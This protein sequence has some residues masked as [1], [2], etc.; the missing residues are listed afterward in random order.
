MPVRTD[1]RT[2]AA[3]M[4][5]DVTAV[6]LFAA[7]GR[8]SHDEGLT[9]AGVAETA[10]PFLAGLGVGWVVSRG[11]R[12]PASLAPTGVTVWVCTVGVGML[13]RR[14]TSSGT[15]VSFV[16]VAGL[17]TGG[18]LVGWR[19]ALRACRRPGRP[20]RRTGS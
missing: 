3:A 19:A 15:A 5:A 10:W 13:L 9:L 2:A 14:A 17:V 4:A 18:L 16:V 20:R 1:T 11:W 12:R 7:L 6:V 8:G